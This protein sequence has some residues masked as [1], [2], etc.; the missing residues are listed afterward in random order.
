M[1]VCVCVRLC[2]CVCV[3]QRE[4]LKLVLTLQVPERGLHTDGHYTVCVLV[5]V[6]R[7]GWGVVM[8]VL[9]LVHIAVK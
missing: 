2:Q 7:L 1:C 5:C 3:R 9:I 4:K 8:T 6:S